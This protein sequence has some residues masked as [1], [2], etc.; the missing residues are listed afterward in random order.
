MANNIKLSRSPIKVSASY[1]GGAD[2]AILTLVLYTG[3]SASRVEE[4]TYTLRKDVITGQAVSFDISQFVY[5]IKRY[6]TELNKL[7]YAESSITQ[8]NVNGS[9]LSVQ[10]STNLVAQGFRTIEDNINL[11]VSSSDVGFLQTNKVVYW[12]GRINLVLPLFLD[13]TEGRTLLVNGVTQ[14]G[15]GFQTDSRYIV[16]NYTRSTFVSGREDF[17]IGLSDGVD[18]ID[19]VLVKALPKD[20]CKFDAMAIEFV[21]R[22]GIVQRIHVG[23]RHSTSVNVTK[24]QYYKNPSYSVGFIVSDNQY[25]DFNVNGRR[26]IQV[27]TGYVSEE[28]N[29]VMKELLLSE[30]VW[31]IP[32]GSARRPVKP[33]TSSLQ[34]KT[35]VSD[36]MINFTLDL[37]YT[38][39]EVI[40]R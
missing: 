27:N 16:P 22:Y 9:S 24:E 11:N 38:F 25:Q 35:R 26:S 14:G 12:D 18:L 33:V 23:A 6:D 39:D 13:N 36:K 5:D 3:T 10:S 37:Q 4:Y 19:E 30:H 15:Y 17:T 28:Y 34:Y 2:Y 20:F 32:K 29:E 21:N 8:Y 1:T 31:V 40:V 7:W